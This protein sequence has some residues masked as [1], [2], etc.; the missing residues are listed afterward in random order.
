MGEQQIL[1]DF[2]NAHKALYVENPELGYAHSGTTLYQMLGATYLGDGNYYTTGNVNT[3]TGQT[4]TFTVAMGFN[5]MYQLE[6]DNYVDY[7]GSNGGTLLFKSQDDQG[8]VICYSGA[9]NN[10]RSIYATCNFGALRNSTSS[11]LQLMTRYMQYFLET[12]VAEESGSAALSGFAL[13]PNPVSDNASCQ[14]TLETPAHVTVSI[15]NVAGQI[16]RDL[17]DDNLP[18]GVHTIKWNGRDD[19][20]AAVGSGSYCL[21]ITVGS[22][23]QTRTIVLVR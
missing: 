21:K 4:G 10:Y 14:F 2:L 12:T 1:V 22:A 20:G 9:G 15:Y 8:R 16:V 18:A 7:I 11:K 13:F 23:V 3:L 6:P 17:T 19:H 5:Y